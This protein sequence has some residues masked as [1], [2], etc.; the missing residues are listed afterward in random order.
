MKIIAGP[1]NLCRGGFWSFRKHAENK[2]EK[3]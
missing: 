1:W 3:Q 2:Q